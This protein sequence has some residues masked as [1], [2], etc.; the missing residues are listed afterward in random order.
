MSDGWH[1]VDELRAEVANLKVQV[2][3][4]ARRCCRLDVLAQV[5]EGGNGVSDGWEATTDT[6]GIW[7][8]RRRDNEGHEV[9]AEGYGLADLANGLEQRVCDLEAQLAAANERAGAVHVAKATEEKPDSAYT[10]A[11][12]CTVAAYCERLKLANGRVETAE[13]ERDIA[14]AEADRC[15]EVCDATAEI[16][17][18][19]EGERDQWHS[20]AS[21]HLECLASVERERSE[22]QAD[23]AA[24]REALDYIGVYEIRDHR[25]RC[26]WCHELKGGPHESRCRWKK[27][28]ATDAGRNMLARVRQL[29]AAL[30]QVQWCITSHLWGT[31]CHTCPLCDQGEASGHSPDCPVGAALDALGEEVGGGERT[32]HW[33]R[34]GSTTT[35]HAWPCRPYEE[36]LMTAACG[37]R[38]DKARVCEDDMLE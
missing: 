10:R 15:R 34:N 30:R 33:M 17:R 28:M 36:S 27:A 38:Q 23:A 31:T 4:F 13:R 16:A 22:A 26:R 37:V 20:Q 14:R 19:N 9:E 21:I 32:W 8:L 18:A 7:S 25:L 29:E 1:R 3:G 11:E 12:A 24:M 6:D 35:F 2:A 5:A